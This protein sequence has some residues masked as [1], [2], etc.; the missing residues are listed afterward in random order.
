MQKNCLDYKFDWCVLGNNC[1]YSEDGKKGT[2]YFDDEGSKDPQN[3]F[4]IQN[5][6]MDHS[7]QKKKKGQKSVSW[8]QRC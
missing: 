5:F 7:F 6:H 4:C 1:L 3:W 2:S 8:F